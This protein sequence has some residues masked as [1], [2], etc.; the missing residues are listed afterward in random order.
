MPIS[1]N[2]QLKLR[3]KNI[4]SYNINPIIDEI[5]IETNEKLK[6]IETIDSTFSGSTCAS[7]IYTPEKIITANV[8]D[9]R[10]VIG[11]NFNGSKILS[12]INI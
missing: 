3:K 5:F 11:R 1:L 10:A 2:S 12:Y 4:L 6:N 7:L 8:G 9:S